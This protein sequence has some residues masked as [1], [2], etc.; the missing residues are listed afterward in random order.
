M[1]PDGG[2]M[3]TTTSVAFDT[4][5]PVLVLKVGD[6][7]LHHGRLGIARSMG[8]VGVPVFGVY[9]DRFAPGAVSKYVLGRFVW[10]ND[11]L[12]TDELLSGMM[13]IAKYLKGPT[14]LV[15]TDD[16][17]AILMAEHRTSLS[18]R[19]VFPVQPTDLPRTVGSKEGLYRLCKELGVPCPD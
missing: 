16:H 9:E 6:Y 12:S 15:P 17:G 2:L 13:D 3:S 1:A 18:D 8:R 4:R 5:V 19:F 11:D 14:I 10:R 7:P